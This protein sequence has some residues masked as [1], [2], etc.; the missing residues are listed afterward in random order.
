MLAT[1]ADQYKSLRP[2]ALEP[3]ATP[4]MALSQATK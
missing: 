3:A 4:A 1:R 2:F